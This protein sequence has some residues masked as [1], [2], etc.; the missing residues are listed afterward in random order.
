VSRMATTLAEALGFLANRCSDSWAMLPLVFFPG[1]GGR[2]GFWRPVAERLADLGSAVLFA[3]PGFG[4]VPAEPAIDSLDGLY[5]WAMTRLPPGSFHLV[6]Q[7]MGG[8]LAARLA[9]EHPERIATLV[10]CATSGGVDVT[11]LGGE[12]WRPAYRAELPD[13]PDW[14]ERDRTDLTARLGE[15]RA[16]TLVLGG[17]RDPICPP[18]VAR[19]LC[20]RIPCTRAEVFAGGAHD[21]AHVHPD[22]VAAAIRR[23]I[24]ALA[25]A[26][27]PSS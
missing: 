14:F 9:I 3:W 17:D 24:S 15:I 1:A 19:L 22:E 11:A 23:H 21:F 18:A 20:D 13:V 2:A 12:D 8:V 10:L 7:S 27:S 25:R 16:P 4:D 26:L 5:R 6:A